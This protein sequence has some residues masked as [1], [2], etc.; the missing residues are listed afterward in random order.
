MNSASELINHP[1]K[2]KRFDTGTICPREKTF[3]YESDKD[4]RSCNRFWFSHSGPEDIS[5]Y[6]FEVATL[7][8]CVMFIFFQLGKLTLKG[9][10][11]KKKNHTPSDFSRTLIKAS[12]MR[13]FN[14]EPL[15]TIYSFIAY[16]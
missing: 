4:G 16:I 3:R 2:E 15:V 1:Q 11:P 13:V 12:N 7:L 8:G 10:T 14:K 6:C 9:Q 5:R